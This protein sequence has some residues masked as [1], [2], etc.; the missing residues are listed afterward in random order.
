MLFMRGVEVFTYSEALKITY[1]CIVNSLL[2]KLKGSF[3]TTWFILIK[4]YYI[5]NLC[6]DIYCIEAITLDRP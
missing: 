3:K 6:D 4:T 5:L 2:S 1:L